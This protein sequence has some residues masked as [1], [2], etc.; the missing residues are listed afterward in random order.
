QVTENEMGADLLQS[1]AQRFPNFIFFKDSSGADRIIKSGKDLGG[2]FA[3]RG[4]E[5]NYLDWV[6]TSGGGYDGFLLSSANTL[7]E[8]LQRILS[9][10]A[11]GRANEARKTSAQLTAIIQETFDLV[12]EMRDGNAFANANKALDHFFAYGP[13]AEKLPTPRLHAGS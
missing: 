4:A 1:I 11:A 6:K 13:E 10:A 12:R 5:G 3:M 9:R 8:Q 7:A 2:V